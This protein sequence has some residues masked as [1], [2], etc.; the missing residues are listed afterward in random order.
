[1]GCEH[2]RRTRALVAD[3]D[4]II[5]SLMETKLAQLHCEAL[6]AADGYSAWEILRN[7]TV[8]LAIIDLQMP[9]IDGFSLIQCM[10]GHP[11]TKH[12]P[13]V[14]L[15]SRSDANAIMEA[16]SVGATSFLT[17]PLQWSTFASHIEYLM[18]LNGR[19]HEARARV[20]KVEAEARLKDVVT[21][22]TLNA[23][24]ASAIRV[25]KLA[26]EAI[27]TLKAQL[28]NE[29]VEELL[30][31]LQHESLSIQTTLAQADNAVSRL[32][33]EVVIN[34]ELV[35]LAK[36]MTAGHEKNLELAN[37]SGVLI[38]VTGA[39]DDVKV[40]CDIDGLTSAIS[41]LVENAV[42]YSNQ[43]STVE[44]QGQIHPDGMLTVSV[45][46]NGAGIEPEYLAS[47]LAPSNAGSENMA[48]T[49]G[50]GLPLVKAICEAHGGSFEIRSF[51]GQGTAAMI[52]I[53]AERVRLEGE[54]EDAA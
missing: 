54:D 30:H 1:M 21:K 15:T 27:D 13:I 22:R 33:M 20:A 7:T 24:M 28:P 4:P 5:C 49:T 29:D 41:E 14:V 46:D 17:K 44:I 34:D 3:D 37:Q 2:S 9:D 10:R 32:S 52:A 12:L 16:F 47:L 48:T 45:S 36:L 25:S 53:P 35:S 11:R 26:K 19:A 23:G 39:V 50:V 38:E 43:G 18:R 31:E 6:T 51:P 40:S 8:D 42:Q